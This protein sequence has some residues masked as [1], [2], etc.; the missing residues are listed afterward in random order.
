MV[1]SAKKDIVH[2]A[3]ATHATMRFTQVIFTPTVAEK[4]QE[5]YLIFKNFN[6][7][8]ENFDDRPH[9]RGRTHHGG[10]VSL[11]LASREE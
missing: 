11:T 1:Y 7:F 4:V 8:S 9:R 3:C 5:H 2:I 6:K 10:T